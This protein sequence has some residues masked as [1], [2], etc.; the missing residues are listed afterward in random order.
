MEKR[1]RGVRAHRS[2]VGGKQKMKRSVRRAVLTVC[3]GVLVWWL[4][5]MPASAL[6][7]GLV[8]NWSGNGTAADA[9]GTN[10]G[11]YTGGYAP[12]DSGQQAFYFNGTTR[13]SATSTNIPTGAAARTVSLWIDATSYSGS[14]DTYWAAYGAAVPD[15]AFQIGQYQDQLYFDCDGTGFYG[16][17]FSLNTWY[18]IAVEQT[19]S[20]A[21]AMYVNGSLVAIVSRTGG[22]LS[23]NTAAGTNFYIGGGDSTLPSQYWA[24]GAYIQNVHVYS[25]ALSGAQITQDMTLPEPSAWLVALP[26]VLLLSATR[27]VRYPRNRPNAA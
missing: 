19:S 13:L 26:S 20:G 27:R 10:N 2:Q 25:V 21:Q 5:L 23:L 1:R 8:S 16:G 3:V 11:T 4:A 12:G 9:T 14:Q 18:Y 22:N 6:P 7:A 15:Q 24:T 17:S